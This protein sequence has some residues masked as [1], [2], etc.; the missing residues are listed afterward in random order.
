MQL[1][2]D[3]VRLADLV[4]RVGDLV[5]GP[6]VLDGELAAVIVNPTR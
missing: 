5:L 2:L 4:G 1:E 6:L 3:V